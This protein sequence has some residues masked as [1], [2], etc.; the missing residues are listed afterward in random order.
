MSYK[1]GVDGGGEVR[2]DDLVVGWIGIQY[3]SICRM[4]NAL[5]R[6]MSFATMPQQS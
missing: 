3:I 6:R 1:V 2:E 5:Q 4:T